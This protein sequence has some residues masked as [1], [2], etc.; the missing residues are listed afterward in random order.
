MPLLG[1]FYYYMGKI[2]APKEFQRQLDPKTCAATSICSIGSP[3]EHRDVW[4]NYMVQIFPELKDVYNDDHKALPRGRVDYDVRNGQLCFFVTL[5][6]CISG[7]EGEIKQRYN[8]DDKYTVNFHY[9]TMNYICRICHAKENG[10][11]Y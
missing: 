5:D 11:E 9:G 6:K 2:I 1:A 4:D 3:L 10:R 7:F 8:L